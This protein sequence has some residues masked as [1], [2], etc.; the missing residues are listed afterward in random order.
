MGCRAMTTTAARFEPQSSAATLAHTAAYSGPS[1]GRLFEASARLY[2][3]RLALADKDRRHTYGEL[4]ARVD[5]IAAALN[6]SGVGAG[7]VVAILSENRAEFVEIELACAKLGV[8]AACQNWRQAPDEL[9]HCVSLVEPK[10]LFASPRYASVATGLRFK[11]P[12]VVEFGF[13]FEEWIRRSARSTAPTVDVDAETGLLILYTSGTTGLPKGAVIS[14]RAMIARSLIMMAE[15]SVSKTDGS[16]GWSP[17][18]H[19]AG[20]DPMFCALIQGAPVILID[21]FDANAICT[22]LEEIPVGWM[23]LLP[24]MIDRMIEALK[25]N[26]TQVRRVAVSGCMANLVPPEQIAEITKLLGAPFLNSF[27]S[28]ETGIVPASGSQ[29]TP[30][31]IPTSFRKL[32]TGY[33]DV[34]V[35]DDN[36]RSVE[37]GVIGE[38]CVRSSTLFSGYWKAPDATADAFRN[39]W[40]HMGDDF[41]VHPDGTLDFVDRRKYLIKSGGENIYPAEIERLVLESDRVQEA[42]VVR[43]PDPKWGEIPVLFVVPRDPAL[44]E[45]AV[46]A[47]IEGR[48]AGYKRPKRIV[49][50]PEA[51]IERNVTGKVRRELL[52]RRL[53][54]DP[55]LGRTQ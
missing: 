2:P 15:W 23:V 52:E 16:I 53:S 29:L 39:G 55:S 49:F 27:G 31:A 47:L 48:I 4:N 5:R 40:Y 9:S 18:F 14:H 8:I 22:A 35:V 44:D 26:R 1:V 6:D 37:P 10:I 33:S 38:I 36:D 19:M 21:G 3:D 32:P 28:T 45:A 30:A 46:R 34:R 25:A 24:G 50:A 11:A 7:D 51:W 54:E 20:N 41:V 43:A 13:A 42:V 12:N 17:L